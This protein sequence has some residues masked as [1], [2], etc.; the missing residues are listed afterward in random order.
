MLSG[1]PLFYKI[2][3]KAIVASSIIVALA[4]CTIVKKY[5]PG[6]P[7]VYKTNINLIGNFSNEE[8]EA[9]IS[10]LEDQLDDSMQVRKLDKLLWSV[11]KNPP[12]YDSSNA[13]KSIIFMQALLRSLGYFRDSI[14]Y[15]HT[16]KKE[17][18]DQ[19]R[20]IVTFNVKPGRQVHL[21]SI[22]YNLRHTELQHITDSTRKQAFIKKGDPFAK[23]PI[24]AELDRLT[25]L[26]RNSGYLRFTRDELVGLWDTLDVSLLQPGI[27]PFEQLEILQRLGERRENPTANLEIRLRSIDSVKLT[28]FYMGNVT[29]YPDY[30]TDTAG[31]TPQIQVVDGI[32][33]VQHR[34]RFKPKIFPP[35]IY[36]PKDSLYRQRRYI[37]TINRL[38]LV[39]AWRTVSIDQIPRG[40]TVD[41]V[42]R[43]IPKKKYSFDTNLEGSINQS[44]FAGNLFGVGVNVSLQN[45]N[46]AKA[47]N[48]TNSNLRYGIELGNIKGA[49]QFIQTQQVSFSHNIYFPRFVPGLKL[50]PEN[51]RDNF[52]TIFSFTAANTERRLLYNLTTIN[53]AWGYEFQRRK[54]LI[55]LK[56][57]NIEYSYLNKRD[58]LDKLIKLNPALRN[59][60]TDGFISSIIANLTLSGGQRNKLNVFR[61]NLEIPEPI[62]TLIR[63]P[64]LDSQLYRFIKFDAEFAHL[65]RFNKSSLAFRVFAGAGYE[66][67]S[68]RNPDKRN[69]LPFFKQ[70]FSGGPNS[71]RA[72]ALRRLGPG[73]TLKEFTD[74]LGT[75]DRYG[76]IQLEANA[77][78]RFPIGK[79]LGIKV[80][81]ALFADVGNVW[82]MKSAAD[83]PA[84][85][86]F[87]LSRLGKDIAIGAG[88]G[89]RIDFDFFVIRFDYSY[90]VKDPSPAL[91]DSVYQNKWFS[92]PFFKGAQFQLG[93][94][95]P[96]IF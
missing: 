32:T 86:I 31:F 84:E 25:D 9:L 51:Y 11:M 71:M 61:A 78:Y 45:R 96:F 3:V 2:S 37:R 57:P 67:N 15:D 73:S 52:R 95:Y 77:E 94:G 40:D 39:G 38:D 12:V 54:V 56:F 53:G 30:I 91:S 8:K 65:I 34:N 55:N 14:Y 82:F 83:R 76:D 46:F 70:Y 42:V 13:D 5:Q 27:D 35:N 72:W 85:E 74:S 41:F 79:P 75:P 59:I 68:T 29:V 64:F 20:T 88:G 28:K 1:K 44:A 69:N 92:Y 48:M 90:R 24:S 17:Q 87:K 58:S 93:I 10:G 26:Y 81:G 62:T 60:F 21:D 4:S 43:L 33:V 89:L 36:L 80:N 7:F 19:L 6:K 23:N 63:T 18:G 66:F 49:G 50:V 16:I 22:N 47:A